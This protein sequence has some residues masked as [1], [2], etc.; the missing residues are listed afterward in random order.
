MEEIIV[1]FKFNKE[2]DSY[3]DIDPELQMEDA[4]MELKDGVNWQLLQALEWKGCDSCEHCKFDAVF[5]Q[6]IC[7]NTAFWIHLCVVD[8]TTSCIHHK[9]IGGEDAV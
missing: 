9:K 3:K 7:R 8:K 1:K 2:W 5:N 4:I 6:N